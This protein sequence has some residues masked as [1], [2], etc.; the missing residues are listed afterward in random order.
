MTAIAAAFEN[1]SCD[2]LII[3]AI[4]NFTDMHRLKLERYL[5]QAE[6]EGLVESNIIGQ[7]SVTNGGFDYLVNHGIIDA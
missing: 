4:N 2:Q 5:R 7:Y 6:K 1:S 3:G